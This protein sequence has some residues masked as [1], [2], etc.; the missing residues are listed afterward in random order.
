MKK[1]KMMMVV[2]VVVVVVRRRKKLWID[3]VPLVHRLLASRYPSSRGAAAAPG[4]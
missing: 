1:K 3:S 2:V 4:R